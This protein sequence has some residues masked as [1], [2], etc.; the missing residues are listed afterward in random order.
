M[1][2]T[3]FP[4]SYSSLTDRGLVRKQ[5]EDVCSAEDNCFVL[6]DGMGGHKAGEVAAQMAVSAFLEK[7][8]A[9]PEG[10]K[11]QILDFCKQAVLQANICVYEAGSNKEEWKGMGTTLTALLFVEKVVFISHVGD[12]RAYRIRGENLKQLTVDHTVMN[13]MKGAKEASL[14]KHV[15]TR[16]VGTQKTV[17]PQLQSFPVHPRD[18]YIL[19]SDGL[20]N[21][22]QDDEILKLVAG[23]GSLEHKSECFVKLAKERGGSDNI[24]L[25]LVEVEDDLPR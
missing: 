8:T 22:V 12:S 6:A 15:L 5:N 2:K 19:C 16:A 20:T 25:I 14:F 1:I 4:L 13:R 21:H 23:R 7:V 24:T 17:R 3:F 10:S 9:F 18:Y 11:D